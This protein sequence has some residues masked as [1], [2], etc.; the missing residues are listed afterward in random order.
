VVALTPA[1]NS[2]P[3]D[4]IRCNAEIAVFSGARCPATGDQL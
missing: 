1:G 2:D 4:S 3:A